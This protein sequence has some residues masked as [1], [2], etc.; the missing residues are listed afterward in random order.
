MTAL[1]LALWAGFKLWTL[2]LAAPGA[3][4]GRRLGYLLLRPGMDADRFLH[5]SIPRP[6]LREALRPGLILLAGAALVWGAAPRL[7]HPLAQGWAGMFGLAL[8]IHFGAFDL[9]S[10]AWRR[11]GIDVPALMDR[12][13]RTR[14]LAELWCRRWNRDFRRLAHRLLFLPLVPR[15]GPHA[16]AFTA[17][18]ASGLVHD[19]V[20]SLPAGGGYG[21]PA[22]CFLI[23][24][25]GHLLEPRRGHRALTVLVA[26]APLP[27]LFPEPFV[28]D[29]ILP[30]LH[31]ME[32]L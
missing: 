29:V 28:L 18:V 3:T 27:L 17:F 19:L 9:A 31:G 21:L 8:M 32:A 5:G 30:L 6:P 22:A 11:A 20:I 15:I 12:P 4:P 25:L 24:D 13:L 7:P 23:Q 1:S 10:V 26:L 14:S 2:V 16:A